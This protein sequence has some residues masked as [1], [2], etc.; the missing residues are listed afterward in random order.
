MT[1]S[2]PPLFHRLL[3][4]TPDLCAE[5]WELLPRAEALAAAGLPGLLLREPSA[6]PATV[7][8]LVAALAPRFPA[9]V[10]HTRSAG[11]WA[12]CEGVL[13]L[14]LPAGGDLRAARARTRGPLG[15]STHGAA[16]LAAATEGGADYALLSPVFAP[17]SKPDDTRPPLGVQACAALA[18]AAGVPVFALGGIDAE[19]ARTL[20]GAGLPG[21]A[22][23][24][25]LLSRKLSPE[26]VY[27]RAVALL[28]ALR[29]P[30][31][32]GPLPQEMR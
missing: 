17:S 8:A 21:V 5:G 25:G 19:R 27:D 15:A 7:R 9:L 14:H 29:G 1:P 12:L 10:L 6:D 30:D 2:P 3:P 20:R 11:A 18:H 4:I 24:G 26:A 16:E 28:N 13:G 32:E 23:L 22:V 31:L